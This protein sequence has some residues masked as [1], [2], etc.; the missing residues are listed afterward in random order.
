MAKVEEKKTMK[1]SLLLPVGRYIHIVG[2]EIVLLNEGRYLN[3][4]SSLLGD[5]LYYV[6]N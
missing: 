5:K 6:L 4:E 1:C 3:K 2:V